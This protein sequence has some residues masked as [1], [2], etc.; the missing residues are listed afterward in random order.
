MTR[1]VCLECWA[2]GRS[3]AP[4]ECPHCHCVGATWETDDADDDP[5]RLPLVFWDID[6]E[7][8]SKTRH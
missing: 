5:R 3:D 4:R 6:P 7:A 1:W 8:R 2:E